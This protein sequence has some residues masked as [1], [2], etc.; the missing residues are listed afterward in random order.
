MYTESQL[1]AIARRENNNKRAY[2]VVN[3]L[4]GKHIPVSPADFFA[5]TKAL[6]MHVQEAYPEERL[7]LVGFA[8]TATAIGASLSVHIGTPYIQTTREPLEDVSWLYF[9]ES[10]SHATEQKLVRED[11][12]QIISSVD[13]IVFVE[14]EITTG[15]TIMKI[16]RILQQEFGGNTAFSVA[17]LLNGMD[18]A[19]R[20]RYEDMQIGLHW[21]VKTDHS[22]YTVIANQYAGDGNYVALT[23]EPLTDSC[24]IHRISGCCNSRRLVHAQTYSAA[25]AT[26]AA[27]VR[28]EIVQIPC[29]SILVLGTEECM[30]PALFVG[31]ALEADGFYVRSHSTTRSPIAVSREEDY[32]LHSRYTLASLYDGA[33]TTYLYDIGRYD[34][35]LIVTDAEPLSDAGV[36]SLV[37]ALRQCGNENGHL[38]QWVT[39]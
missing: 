16:I 31:A 18:D 33:R 34:M 15:N 4:Q 10:H 37:H 25:C 39:Q 36:R 26:L 27:R 30:Y 17:S 9:T 7:L 12:A 35:V 32:P 3:R 2:L 6:A 38:V 11:I 28:E 13:R 21:L 5:M 8:E 20:R 22:Q 14:D 24:T 29:G 1:A 19:S 23:D